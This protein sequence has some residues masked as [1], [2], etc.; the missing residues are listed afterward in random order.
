MSASV[1]GLLFNVSEHAYLS[2]SAGIYRIATWLRDHNIDVEVVDWASYWTLEQLKE[3]FLSRYNNKTKFVGF[4]HLF[5]IWNGPLEDF[6][7][8]IKQNYPD[9]AIISGSSV[10]PI[11][12]SQHIDYY[13]QGYGEHAILELLK[14]LTSNGPRPRFSLTKINNKPVISANDTYSAYPMKSLMIRYEDRD[15]VKPNEWLTIETSR[16]CKFKCSFCNF[17]VLGVK[18]D[19]SRDAEDFEAQLQDAYHRFGVT[20]YILADETFND[21]TE[22]ITKFADVVQK[23]DFVPYFSAYV[24]ADLMINRPQDREELLRMNVLGHFYGIESFNHA[25]AKAVGKGMNSEKV[26]QGLIDARRYFESHTDLYRG[27]ISLIV[28]LPYETV[29]SLNQSKQWLIDHWQGHSYNAYPLFIPG[30]KKRQH[31]SEISIDFEK[32]GYSH[33]DDVAVDP[34][35]DDYI[36]HVPDKLLNGE[37]LW[38]NENLDIFQARKITDEWVKQKYELGFKPGGFMLAQKLRDYHSI[39]QKIKLSYND[40]HSLRDPDISDYI[41]SKLNV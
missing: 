32:Y 31:P 37:Y 21:R 34:G 14:W 33:C 19:Y 18:G 9:L 6:C 41:K 27:T 8:W 16:G 2:R 28:G 3:F 30:D 12:E 11:F 10:N 22:K 29:E 13:I 23:L 1:H 5:S 39:D 4:S 7:A 40:F 15:F 17:P 24:R 38:K 20:N 36:Y 35:Y 26:K 25:S